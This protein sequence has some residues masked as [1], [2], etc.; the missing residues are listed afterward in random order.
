M[1][2]L[3]I[4]I[5]FLAACGQDSGAVPRTNGP[6]FDPVKQYKCADGGIKF[7]LGTA[8]FCATDAVTRLCGA[9]D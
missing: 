1:K 7:T 4:A 5:L 6:S 9:G 2:T 3:L 8:C